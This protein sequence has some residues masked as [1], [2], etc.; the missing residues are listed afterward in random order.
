MERA[1]DADNSKKFE[2]IKALV[3]T[4]IDTKIT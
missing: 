1:G 3:Q 2:S 4:V